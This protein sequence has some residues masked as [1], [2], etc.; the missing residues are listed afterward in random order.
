MKKTVTFCMIKPDSFRKNHVGVILSQLEKAGF[1]FIQ[2]R[3]MKLTASFC[4]IFYQEHK[5]R[6]F[7]SS[8]IEFMTSGP[9]L[10]LVLEKE[11]AYSDLR[12]LMGAT[13]PGKADSSSI[14]RHFG[15][16]IEQNAIHGSDSLASAQR[17]LALFFPEESF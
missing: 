4:E 15:E 5:Q 7:F 11:N 17:E 12:K 3:Q 6:P 10:A 13:D 14:R 16:N 2:A 8:L 9:V 1:R